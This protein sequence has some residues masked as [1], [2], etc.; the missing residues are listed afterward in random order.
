MEAAVRLQNISFANSSGGSLRNSSSMPRTP[1]SSLA[2]DKSSHALAG[3]RFYIDPDL[4]R[5]LQLK[6]RD[7]SYVVDSLRFCSSTSWCAQLMGFGLI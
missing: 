4:P 3:A 1:H 2:T 5:D 6:V 7:N